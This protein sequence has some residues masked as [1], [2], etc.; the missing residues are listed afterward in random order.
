MAR[1]EAGGH[2][3]PVHRVGEVLVP[4]PAHVGGAQEVALGELPVG[5]G[6]EGG[7]GGRA[8]QQLTGQVVRVEQGQRGG[9][10]ASLGVTGHRD[11]GRVEAVRVAVGADPVEGGAGLAQRDRVARPRARGC[12][13]RRPPP[14][15]SR[16]PVR[17]RADRG[18][19][20]RRRPS[21]R[22][23]RAR[24]AAAPSARTGRK[25]VEAGVR[26]ELPGDAGDEELGVLEVADGGAGLGGGMPYRK[27]GWAVASASAWAA[28]S[29]TCLRMT[30]PRVD[31]GVDLRT[32]AT[33]QTFVT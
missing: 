28:S 13:R 17:G 11:P 3:G 31:A 24:R 23:G 14:R 1:S 33:P 15:R 16:G 2:L 21:R 25:S 32:G 9:Q 8:E 20:R 5:I 12:S 22:A 26:E 27:G 29:S 7:V 30:A 18:C 19:P 4:R 10:R 6:V